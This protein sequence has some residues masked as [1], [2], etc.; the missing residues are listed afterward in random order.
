M[1]TTTHTVDL[2]ILGAGWT[3]TFLIPL[4]ESRNVTYAATTHHQSPSL[5]KSDKLIFFDFDFSSDDPAP[6]K[7]LPHA[8]TVLISFPIKVLGASERLVRLYEQT[9]EGA[10]GKTGFIQLGS[11]GIWDRDTL[12]DESQVAG[13]DALWADRHTPYNTANDRANEEAEL[14]KLS[15]ASLTTVLD[16]CGLWGGDRSMKHWVGKVVPTKEALR[17]KGGIHLIHGLDVSRA[18]LAVHR[19]FASRA[20]GQRWLLT[21]QRVYDWWDLAS[22]WGETHSREKHPN[23][24]A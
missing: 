22:A 16:L 3:S 21:D 13:K 1:S 6:F 24:E 12:Q 5:G 11:T 8:K 20:T 15:P 18:I 2:L 14:L 9:H 17:I 19:H 4:C 10:K 7:A 23:Q